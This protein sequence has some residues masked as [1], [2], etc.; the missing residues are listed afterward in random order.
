MALA[1]P[2]ESQVTVQKTSGGVE[3]GTWSSDITAPAPTLFILAG[4]IQSTLD[5]KYFRQCG[6]ALAE[7]G[8]LCVSIDIPCHGSQTRSDQP[9]GLG[10]WSHRAGTDDDFV[11]EFN[12]RMSAVLDHLIESGAT[13]P[14]KVAVCGTSR[15]GFLAY[16]FAAHDP[17]VKCAAGFAPATDLAALSE[18]K[19]KEQHPL[20][21]RLSVLSQADRLAGRSVWIIIG[22]QDERVGTHHAIELAQGITAASLAK[23]VPSRVELHVM[24]EPRGHTTPRG[25]SQ[26]AAD[27]IHRE[28]HELP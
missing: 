1:D 14:S 13:D 3:F 24:P 19:G 12:A 27:W 15:G 5:S 17:R 21:K 23:K 10:G 25:A 11:A 2:G 16:H 8:Y 4:T 9:N 7:R 18:F 6:N 22:D 26:L 20:V 28:L